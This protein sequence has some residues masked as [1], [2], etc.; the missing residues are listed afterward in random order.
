MHENVSSNTNKLSSHYTVFQININ[1]FAFHKSQ[2]FGTLD[3]NITSWQIIK[4]ALF[5][6]LIIQNL[7]F[8]AAGGYNFL[9]KMTDL[10]LT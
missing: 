10:Y 5:N 6:L 3:Q 9:L 4:F 2:K 7:Y 1:T 8:Q